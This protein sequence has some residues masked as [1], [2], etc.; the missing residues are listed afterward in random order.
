MN[1]A[2]SIEAGFFALV[3]AALDSRLGPIVEQLAALE[4]QLAKLEPEDEGLTFKQAARALKVT[5]RTIR[6]W[7]TEKKIAAGGTPRS[8]RIPRSE[9]RRVLHGREESVPTSPIA[10]ESAGLDM[11]VLARQVLSAGAKRTKRV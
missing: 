6:R 11:T 7:V 8:R 9:L 3:C 4:K 1:P 2:S 10:A 5:P